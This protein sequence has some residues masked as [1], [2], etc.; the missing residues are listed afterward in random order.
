MKRLL[1]QWV[2]MIR[3]GTKSVAQL[4][5]RWTTERIVAQMLIMR[6][7]ANMKFAQSWVVNGKC[8]IS[9]L[10][11]GTTR[12]AQADF[13]KPTWLTASVTRSLTDMLPIMSDVLKPASQFYS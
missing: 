3:G 12:V 1:L 13:T 9:L 4:A 11:D 8:E 10:V 7:A 6:L 2:A 5:F